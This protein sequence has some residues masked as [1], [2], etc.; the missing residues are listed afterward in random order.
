[1]KKT[2]LTT[3]VA[4]MLMSAV[5]VAQVSTPG[6]PFSVYAGGALSLP[7]SPEGFRDGWKFG[8]HGM[9]GVGFNVAPRIQMIGKFEYHKF[10]SDLDTFGGSTVDGGGFNSIMFGVDG[11]LNLGAPIVP[12]KPYALGGIGIASVSFDEYTSSDPLIASSLNSGVSTEKFSKFYFN[13]GAGVEFT[14]APKASMF[15]QARYVNVA[16]DGGSTG[17]IPVTL[18]LKLF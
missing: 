3:L 16:T 5:S 11:R 8:Y 15:V 13:F 1:M 6:L 9:L 18:G 10:Q 2:I 7:S 12:I 14:L 17:Y 4:L